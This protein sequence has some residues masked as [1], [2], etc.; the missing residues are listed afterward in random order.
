MSPIIIPGGTLTGGPSTSGMSASVIIDAVIQQC[1]TDA[2]RVTVLSVLNEMYAM[3]LADSRWFRTQASIGTTV[4][5]TGEYAVPVAIIEAYGVTVGGYTYEP[6]G[7]DQMWLIKQGAAAARTARGG[8]YAQG[9]DSV[10]NATITFHP[11]PATSGEDIVVYAALEGPALADSVSSIPITPAD[12]HSSLID[13]TAGTILTRVDE[14]P[15]LGAPFIASYQ[16]VTERLRRRK[17]QLLRGGKPV[18][19]MVSGVHF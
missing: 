5:G 1:G 18:Q 14:R 3:Q 6:I 7:E 4:A 10:G 12:S 8:L 13:G 17:N 16:A 2:S 15:D 19:L 11:T 9:Y